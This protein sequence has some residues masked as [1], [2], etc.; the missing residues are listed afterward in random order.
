M[1][2]TAI[3]E[4][5]K[6]GHYS[7]YVEEDLPGFGLSGFGDT[8]EAAK[9]DMLE[10]YKEIKEIQAEEGKEVPE[11]EFVYKYDMQS[12]FDYFSFLNV[13]KVAELAGINPS[14]MRQYTSGVT[15]AGQKQ[16]DKIR[17]AVERISKELSE[18][19]F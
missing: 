2:V 11:L 4:K 14:L 1:K 12:F 17:V 8:A 3:M 15:N 19:T 13:T 5:A 16:Y 10:A 7:C 6:D 9:G 18:A